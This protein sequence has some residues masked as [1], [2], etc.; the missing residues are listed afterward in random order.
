[1]IDTNTIYYINCQAHTWNIINNIIS[2][3]SYTEEPDPN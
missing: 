1:M 3:Y 2:I